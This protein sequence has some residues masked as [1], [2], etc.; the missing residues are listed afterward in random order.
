METRYLNLSSFYLTDKN[1]NIILTDRDL[2]AVSKVPNSDDNFSALELTLTDEGRVKLA[3]ATEEIAKAAGE[4][5]YVKVIVGE[6]IAKPTVTS[7]IDSEKFI[8]Q[9]QF[10]ETI[11]KSIA[12]G[13]QTHN[14]E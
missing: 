9:G 7:K 6:I 4:E 12:E 3:N 13:I 10:G 1:N 11:V 8:V 5:N 2:S 14:A